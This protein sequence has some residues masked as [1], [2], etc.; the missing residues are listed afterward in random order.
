MCHVESL[1]RWAGSEGC[2]TAKCARRARRPARVAATCGMM[3]IGQ[4]GHCQEAFGTPVV[5][6]TRRR[7]LKVGKGMPK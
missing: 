7:S 1:L 6:E 4:S 3:P 2:A 5:F